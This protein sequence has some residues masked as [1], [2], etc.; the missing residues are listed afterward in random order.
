MEVAERGMVAVAEASQV[1][2][3]RRHATAI[4]RDHGFGEVDVGRVAIAV[5]EAATNLVKHGGGGEIH[6]STLT[7]DAAR[8]M[9]LIAIDRGPGIARLAEAARDGFSTAGSAG[10]GLGAIARQVSQLDMFSAPGLGT[11]LVACLWAGAPLADGTGLLFGAMCVPKPGQET[12][13][14]GWAVARDEGR[15]LVLVAD[16]L[17]HGPEAAEASA[18]AKAVLRTQKG[19]SPAEI[20]ERMHA[21]LRGTRGA[22]AA[23]AEVSRR[24]VVRFAG[25]GNVSGTIVTGAT[26][27]SLV[28]HHGT[29]GHDVRKVQEFEYPWAPGALLVLHSDGLRARWTLDAYPGLAARHPAVVAAVLYRDFGRGS[30]DATVVVAR[31]AS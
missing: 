31:D 4:A 21:A 25:I 23:V 22:A 2:E 11:V 27:R 12:C 29:L 26:T 15:T 7:A 1:G 14:D 9:A 30:D 20:I 10:T 3:A 19:C 17:G 24:G 16:G 5:T 18:S 13:G 6:V 8:G 28:S